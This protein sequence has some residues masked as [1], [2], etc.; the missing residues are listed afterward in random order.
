MHIHL[1]ILTKTLYL[2][3]CYL[4]SHII[5]VILRFLFGSV[6]SKT[7][8]GP[9]DLLRPPPTVG[10]AEGPPDWLTAELGTKFHSWC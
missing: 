6:R 10:K 3:L 1:S 7:F 9:I 8:S 4:E 5:W 2:L